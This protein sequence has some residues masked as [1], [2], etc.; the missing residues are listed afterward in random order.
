MFFA[1]ATLDSAIG[2]VPALFVDGRYFALNDIVPSLVTDASKGLLDVLEQWEVAEPALVNALANGATKSAEPLPDM[3]ARRFLPPILYPS[4][5]ICAGGN[6]YDHLRDDVGVN[7]FDKSAHDLAY[8]LKPSRAVVGSG[9]SVRYPSQSK[10]FDW[11]IELAVLF[12]KRGRRIAEKD[13]MS[14]VAGYSVG[15][16]LSA[17]DWLLNSRHIIK[18]DPFGGKAFDDCAPLGPHFVPARFVD[19]KDLKLQ[20]WVN[21]EL[22]Q[23]SHTREMIWSIPEQIAELSQVMTVEPGDVLF[24]GS[25]GGVGLASETFLKIGDRIEAEISG[26][27]RLDIEVGPD[28]DAQAARPAPIRAPRRH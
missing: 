16:D 3:A 5:I 25:P 22:R 20:L 26:L 14:Y 8:F 24:T 27:G 15:L 2:P 12:G 23:N 21:G 4:K 17:R 19:S 10:Q 7:D 9:M 28:P 18:F 11:E 1:L 13:A 6:Y